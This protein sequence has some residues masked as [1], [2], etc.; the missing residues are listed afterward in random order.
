[1]PAAGFLRILWAMKLNRIAV[2][3]A[4]CAAFVLIARGQ[5]VAK[6]AEGDYVT[7][8]FHFRSGEVLPEL[9]L[10]YA[11]YGK[12]ATDK[13]GHVTNAVMILHGTTGSGKQFVSSQFA[14]V[15][16]GRGQLFGC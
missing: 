10:H 12:P 14:G 11:T 5:D 1:M 7:H 2:I 6:P 8:N 16:F 4:V 3:C 9:K 15:L 13:A